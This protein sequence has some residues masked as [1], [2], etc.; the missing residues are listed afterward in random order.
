MAGPDS[1]AHAQRCHGTQSLTTPPS[2]GNEGSSAAGGGRTPLVGGRSLDA[3]PA[4]SSAMPMSRSAAAKSWIRDLPPHRPPRCPFP[5]A[6][7]YP[8]RPIRLIVPFSPGGRRRRPRLSAGARW[9]PTRA[10]GDREQGRWRRR[11]GAS[12]RSLARNPIRLY[13]CLGN[14]STQVL[15]PAIIS[16]PPYDAVKDFAGVYVI[17]LSPTCHRRARSVPART[18]TEFIAYAKAEPHQAVLW[19]G[20]RRHH[21]QLVGRAVERLDRHTR[22][23]AHPPTRVPRPA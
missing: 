6:F 23:H 11:M 5:P 10:G 4:G 3:F 21:D 12:P 17:C 19:Y 16:K 15:I 22:D 1:C 7:A 18:L 8:D 14:T 2:M 20:R 9:R 13:V